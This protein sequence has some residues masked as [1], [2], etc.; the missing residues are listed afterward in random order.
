MG[1]GSTATSLLCI[2]AIVYV[3]SIIIKHQAFLHPPY[4][5]S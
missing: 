4:Y 2:N 1:G 5:I 3:C